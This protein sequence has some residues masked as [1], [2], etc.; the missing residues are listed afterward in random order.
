MKNCCRWRSRLQPL[1]DKISTIISFIA[2]LSVCSIFTKLFLSPCLQL[3]ISSNNSFPLLL[4]L[5][6]QNQYFGLCCGD[7]MPS[8]H[9]SLLILGFL[10]YASLVTSFVLTVP[11]VQCS[12][13]LPDI[14]LWT[15]C[16]W[17]TVH[18]I[19][20]ESFFNLSSFPQNNVTK[21]LSFLII[22][23]IPNSFLSIL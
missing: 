18:H 5:S 19:S 11:F 23:S 8:H 12:S 6:S 9:S 7:D 22:T 2:H 15:L 21:R 16:T 14:F 10:F 20:S 13:C 3:L 17:Y 4:F 1:N